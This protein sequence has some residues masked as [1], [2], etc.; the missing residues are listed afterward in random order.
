[1]SSK[2]STVNLGRDCSDADMDVLLSVGGVKSHFAW[3][4]NNDTC[5]RLT[6]Q[7]NKKARRALHLLNRSISRR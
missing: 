4:S 5:V 3:Q 7:S 6:F 2:E 1:M